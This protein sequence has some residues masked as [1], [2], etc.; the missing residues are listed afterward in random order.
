MGNTLGFIAHNVQRLR[1]IIMSTFTIAIVGL[2]IVIT[3]II[4]S[5][6][7]KQC[8]RLE[9]HESISPE[10]TEL[11]CDGDSKEL[12][13]PSTI[14]LRDVNEL[15]VENILAEDIV[16]RRPS[17]IDEKEYREI[18][19]DRN[20]MLVQ[21]TGQALVTAN[22]TTYT[23]SQLNKMAPNGLFT[24]SVP[25][26]DI[27]N[28]KNGLASSVKY[29]SKGVLTH[30]G[31]V[32]L[33]S[34]QIAHVSPMAITAVTMQGAAII[35][36]Q[37]HLVQLRKALEQNTHEIGELKDL[38]EKEVIGKLLY[39]RSRLLEI[40]KR[41]TCDS[42]DITDIRNCAHDAG[43]ILHEYKLRYDDAY[44][45]KEEFYFDGVQSDKAIAEFNRLVNKERYLQQ[46]CLLAERVLV[47]AKLVEYASRCK[48]DI[49][50][51]EI[52]ELY[53]ELA[54]IN[55]NGYTRHIEEG[56]EKECEH[57]RKKASKILEQGYS[58][59]WIMKHLG[60]PERLMTPINDT[61]DGFFS[62]YETIAI[63]NYG[64]GADQQKKEVL[65]MID[66]ETGDT[67]LFEAA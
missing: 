44:K 65:L 66:E 3:A 5:V 59:L 29:S 10:I 25:L 57:I 43:Q 62:D 54:D 24:G 9:R 46:V 15:L 7:I 38:H 50:D 41:Q 67:R 49:S 18:V 33:D 34:S 58:G 23:I 14:K 11:D 20:G 8:D 28:Y 64:Q 36:G 61:I 13:Y 22:Q 53:R 63:N 40:A 26:S 39:C 45:V 55:Q 56:I 35:T 31:F 60:E 37:Y 51:S 42:S 21:H 48:M 4:T 16:F 2:A 32:P 6:I 19:L 17:L 30:N 12:D 1:R 52:Q 47:E 27:S